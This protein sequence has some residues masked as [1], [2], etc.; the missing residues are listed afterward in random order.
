MIAG[1]RKFALFSL[2]AALAVSLAIVGAV[3]AQ[4][5]SGDLV[6]VVLDKTG[7]AVP[8]A[9]IEAVNTQTGGKLTTE[10]N[11]NGEYRLNNLPVGTYNVLVF[12]SEFAPPQSANSSWS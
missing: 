4:V 3:S 9:Q 1:F 12:R 6:G 8:N 2:L 7:A 11:E 5:I 10:S